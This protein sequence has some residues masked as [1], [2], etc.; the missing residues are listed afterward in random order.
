M[1]PNKRDKNTIVAQTKLHEAIMS[2]NDRD[3]IYNF[4]NELIRDNVAYEN[5]NQRLRRELQKK[6]SDES[7]QE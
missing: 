2:G 1:D 4:M 7:N 3:F 6:E 5:E